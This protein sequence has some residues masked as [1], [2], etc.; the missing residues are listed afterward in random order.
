MSRISHSQTAVNTEAQRGH[1]K[2]RRAELVRKP[3]GLT[4]TLTLTKKGFALYE[5]D[6]PLSDRCQH[7]SPERA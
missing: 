3:D 7:R 6:I 5:Q 4:P 1:K 2:S